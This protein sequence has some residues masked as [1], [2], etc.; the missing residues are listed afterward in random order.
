MSSGGGTTPGDTTTTIRYP[1]YVENHHSTFLDIVAARRDAA[2]DASPFSGYSG[3]DY[4]DGFFGSGYT[5]ASFPSLYDMYG[6]FMAGLD[7]E[8]LFTQVLDDSINNSAID[9][10]VSRHATKLSSDLE[11]HGLPRLAAGLRDINSVISSSFN[12][13]RSLLEDARVRE[14]NEFDAELRVRM[15]PVAVQRFGMHLD[16]NHKVVMTY[17][18]M[19]KLYLSAAMDVDNHNYTMYAKD[20]LWP[21]TILEY[22]RAA[23]G[24]LQGAMNRNTDVAGASQ[25][26]KAIG[27]A[28]T[29]AAAG[30]MVGGPY[31]AAIGGALG[32]ASAF[33]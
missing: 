30:A 20:S 6:K 9:T 11:Q 27:G 15:L 32:L 5:L 14:L 19:L 22:N 4:A 3:I 26:Q 29:G 21:F 8:N 31:G 16:W 13:A 12:V 10:R 18:D 2:I 24:A 17:A 7:I 25:T 1:E 28:L 23:L 33:I